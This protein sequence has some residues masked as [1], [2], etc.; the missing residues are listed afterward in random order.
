MKR[1]NTYFNAL[2]LTTI[3]RSGPSWLGR[4]WNI[5]AITKLE[6]EAEECEAGQY[7]GFEPEVRIAATA[8]Q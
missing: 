4:I 8:G 5:K 2:A 3:T 7:S 6:L 1:T